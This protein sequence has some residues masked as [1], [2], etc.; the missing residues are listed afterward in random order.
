MAKASPAPPNAEAV[1][2]ELKALGSEWNRT[3]MARF[4]INTDRAFGVSMAAMRPLQRKYRHQHELAAEL[5]ATGYH[6]A[7]IL[8]ALIDDPRE[9]R[10]KQRIREARLSQASQALREAGVIGSSASTRQAAAAM[11]SSGRIASMSARGSV[12]GSTMNDE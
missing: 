6:E 10:P 8:A 12:M 5:W 4:G 3:G 11:I 9:V 2:A 7:R 1:L